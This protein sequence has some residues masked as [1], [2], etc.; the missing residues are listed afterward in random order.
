ML[1]PDLG[2]NNDTALAPRN[3][4]AVA[5]LKH[6]LEMDYW[7]DKDELLEFARREKP[8]IGIIILA[9]L[10]ALKLESEAEL[11]PHDHGQNSVA[12]PLVRAERYPQDSV[13]RLGTH[14]KDVH[15]WLDTPNMPTIPDPLRD[16]ILFR[17]QPILDVLYQNCVKIGLRLEDLMQYTCPSPWYSPFPSLPSSLVPI[18]SV[19]PDLYPTP[20]QRRIPHHPFIDLIPFPWLRERAVTLGALDPPPFDRFELKQDVISNGMICWKSSTAGNEGLPW[21]RRNW[22]IQPWFQSKWGWLIEEQGRIEQQSRW[23]RMQRHT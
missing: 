13:L 2:V 20:A 17:R 18:E 4:P 16:G 3:D 19:P 10:R 1:L 9:G 22:E 12:R 14:F 23:W 7:K 6:V 5:G 15:G 8:N 11:V 21:D